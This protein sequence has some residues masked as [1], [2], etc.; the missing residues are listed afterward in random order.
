MLY[1]LVKAEIGKYFTVNRP[2][3][4]KNFPLT[5]VIPYED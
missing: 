1:K 4:D 5:F 3:K 2:E